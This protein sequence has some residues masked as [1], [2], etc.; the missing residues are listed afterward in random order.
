MLPEQLV[1]EVFTV[2]VAGFMAS[3]KVISILELTEVPVAPFLGEKPLTSGGSCV[4]SLVVVSASVL[5]V[6]VLPVS[7]LPVSVLPVSVLPVSVLPVS[8]LPVSVLPISVLPVSVLP[9]EALPSSV[10]AVLDATPLV[11]ALSFFLSSSVSHPT[12]IKVNNSRM[13]KIC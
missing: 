2:I 1:S 12:Q 6:S 7:V 13:A 11:T 8:V 9:V 3:L 10:K 4:V 5:P